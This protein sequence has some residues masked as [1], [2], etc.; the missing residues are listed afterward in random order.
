VFALKHY[1]RDEYS[2]EYDDLK[3][4]IKHLPKVATPS[5]NI[6]LEAQIHVRK[7]QSEHRIFKRKA[8]VMA[9]P[10]NIPLEISYYFRT[11]IKYISDNKLS[12]SW[13]I[14]VMQECKK[15]NSVCIKAIFVI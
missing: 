12:D 9:T 10:T 4:F 15:L 7:V 14:K 2:Y 1:V 6:P 13:S 5:S 11:Y 3:G 8:Y